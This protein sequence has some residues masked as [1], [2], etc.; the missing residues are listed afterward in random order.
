MDVFENLQ[1]RQAAVFHVGINEIHALAQGVKSSTLLVGEARHSLLEML[2]ERLV[3][4]DSFRRRHG[5]N[6]LEQLPVRGLVPRNLTNKG[7]LMMW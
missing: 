3:D 4:R 2:V 6:P 1:I 7:D 5:V